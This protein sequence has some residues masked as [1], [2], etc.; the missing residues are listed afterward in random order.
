MNSA[1]KIDFVSDVSCPWCAI[2]L[3]SLERALERLDGEVR[4]ELHFQPFELNPG[5]PPGGEDITEHLTRKYRSTPAQQAQSRDA[6]RERGA[7]VGFDFRKEGR[8]RIYNT[9][10]AH[11]L[12]HWAALEHPGRQHALKK[13]LLEAYFT[14]GRSPEDREVLVQAAAQAGLDPAR[15]REVLDSGEFAAAVRER[16][17]FYLDHGIHAVPAVIVNDRHLIQGG[18]PPEVF[19]EALRRIAAGA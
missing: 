2:G 15:A 5:M 16:E 14:E 12:L 1:L 7:A 13:A 19:E 11:R 4:A 9:F 18:Q 10:D 3:A 17:Q 6:I 8:G